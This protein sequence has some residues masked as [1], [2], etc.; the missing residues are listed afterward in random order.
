[1]IFLRNFQ[2]QFV[3]IVAET[4]IISPEGQAP[5]VAHGFVVDMDNDFVYLGTSNAIQVDSAISKKH[6][7]YICITDPEQED[8]ILFPGNSPENDEELN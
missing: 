5:L 4:G 6:I 2:N 3:E 7:V 8:A 1:M